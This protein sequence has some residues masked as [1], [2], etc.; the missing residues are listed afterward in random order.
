MPDDDNTTHREKGTDSGK[1]T[2]SVTKRA[3]RITREMWDRMLAAYKEKPT[4]A[5]IMEQANVGRLTAKQ[6]V[7]AG[8]P[9]FG[10]PPFTAMEKQKSTMLTEL[11]KLNRDWDDN[12]T[13]KNEAARQAAQEAWAARVGMDSAVRAAKLAHTYTDR[14][15]KELEAGNVE[16]PEL[17]PNT[18]LSLVRALEAT[19][20]TL[21]KAMELQQKRAGKPESTIG[22]LVIDL[23]ERCT[24]DEL[25]VVIE[26][27]GR[28]PNRILGQ[29]KIIDVALGEEDKEEKGKA[30][31]FPDTVPVQKLIPGLPPDLP[32]N[33]APVVDTTILRDLLSEGELG[34]QDCAVGDF[35]DE[36]EEELE[37]EDE[38]ED[39]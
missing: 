28:L 18:L 1:T 13:A 20:T 31:R 4:L 22:G 29:K 9:K 39:E 5:Y 36:D 2:V 14:V 33:A 8:W 30:E 32:S 19:N 35:D 6:A 26:S 27:G 34:P 21:L 24:D 38:D 37:D 11:A 10:W 16:I 12:I 23:L 17:K 25:S 7:H 3:P 15:F